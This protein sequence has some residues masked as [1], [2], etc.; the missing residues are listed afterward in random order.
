MKYT[1]QQI[2]NIG[3]KRWLKHKSKRISL[4]YALSIAWIPLV[5]W[6]VNDPKFLI[7]LTPLGLVTLNV[8]WS[9]IQSRNKFYEKVKRNP[10]LLD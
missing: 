4:L 10:E 3:G 5:Y 9:Y 8:V 1:A 6:L 2:R 7:I